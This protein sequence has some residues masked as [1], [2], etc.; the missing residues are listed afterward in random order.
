MRRL[1]PQSR[2]EGMVARASVMEVGEVLDSGNTLKV[3]VPVLADGLDGIIKTTQLK[4][5]KLIIEN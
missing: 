1:L 5:K 3:E 2:Q 4:R